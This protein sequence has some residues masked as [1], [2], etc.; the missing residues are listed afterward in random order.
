[1]VLTCVDEGIT[2]VV[3]TWASSEEEEEEE[4]EGGGPAGSNR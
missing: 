3:L 2:G 1:M 4:E